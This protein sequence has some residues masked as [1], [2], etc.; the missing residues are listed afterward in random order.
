MA[1]CCSYGGQ[2]SIAHPPYA[3]HM[4]QKA[5]S[6]KEHP[7]ITYCSN[8]RDIFVKSG[9]KAVHILDLIFDRDTEN[10]ASPTVSERQRNRLLLKNQLLDQ[11][12][13]EEEVMEKPAA[14][15]Q[16]STEIKEKLNKN[17]ILERDLMAVIEKSEK[18]GRKLFDPDK[19]TFTSYLQIGNMTY[20]AEYKVIKDDVFK[21]INGYC[22]RMK[23]EE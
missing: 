1:S 5:V 19:N 6:Q 9:K 14:E 17:M 21:V 10:R 8:C 7:Y 22:H 3:E 11:F 16:I 15:L 4:V 13:N 12:W 2:V 20:W 18:T 23:V